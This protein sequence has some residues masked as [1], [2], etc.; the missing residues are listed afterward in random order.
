VTWIA[1]LVVSYLWLG[2]RQ[3]KA[4]SSTVTMLTITTVVLLF[5]YYFVL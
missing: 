5:V 1:V 4:G 2:L 3:R